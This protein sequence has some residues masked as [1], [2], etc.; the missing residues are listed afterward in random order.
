MKVFLRSALL[1][2]SLF[3]SD[4]VFA[5]LPVANFT[6]TPLTG[7]APLLVQFTSTSTGNP[8]SYQWNL[9]NGVNTVQQNPSTAY[10]LPGT[11]TVT[12]TVTNANGSDT[13]VVT[14]YITVV[15]NPTIT[16]AALDSDGCP[17]FP[18]QFNNTT[19]FNA[20]GAGTY[21]WSFG[22]G[23]I[24]SATNPAHTYASPGLYNVTLIAT[25]SA[26]CAATL[27]K[28]AYINV[29]TPP[30]ATFTATPTSYCGTPATIGFTASSTGTGPHTYSWDFGDGGTGVGASPSHVYT[31]SGI[32][33]VT[34][35]A[36]DANG[37]KD[38]VVKPNYVSVGSIVANFTTSPAA[39][40]VNAPLQFNNT[41]NGGVTYYWNFGDGN[42][43]TAASPAHTYMAPG[44]YN[45]KLAIYD[46]PCGDSVTKQITV[47][48]SPTPNF[49]FTPNQPCPAPVQVQFNNFTSGATSYAWDFGDGGTSS[50]TSP[51]HTYGMNNSFP[52]KLI[53]TN[54][55]GCSAEY[56]DT[57]DVFSLDVYITPAY[58]AGCV[59][60]NVNFGSVIYWVH[61][62]TLGW[63]TYPY[64]IT[65]YSW[66]FGDG[67]TSALQSPSHSY[68]NANNTY[69]AN[70]TVTTANGCTASGTRLVNVGSKPTASFID[71]PDTVCVKTPVYFINTTTDTTQFTSYVW[72]MG[73]GNT[74]TTKNAQHPYTV[75]GYYNVSLV[76]ENYG[77]KD[78]FT[79]DTAAVVNA[80]TAIWT[81]R[82]SCDTPLLVQFY[83]TLS[84]RPTSH[85]WYFGDGT[86]DT[87][88]NPL[89]AYPSLG[90][91]TVSLVTFN[92]LYGCS[93]TETRS[94]EIIDPLL[95]FTT[96]DTAICRGD[97]ILFI[98]NYTHTPSLYTW[99][100]DGL[101]PPWPFTP[102]SNPNPS[103]GSWGHRFNVKGIYDISVT[104]TDIHGCKDSAYRTDYVLVAKPQALFS[105]TPTVGCVPLTVLF[106]DTSTNVPGA[107]SVTRNWTFGNGA[108]TVNTDTTSRIYP[109]AGIY[110]V[111][112][113]VTDNV[114]CKDTLSKPNYIDVRKPTAGFTVDDSA[115]CI[116]QALNFTSNSVGIGLSAYWDFGDGTNSAATNPIKSYSQAGTFSVKLIVTDASG[117]KD[118]LTK[119]AYITITKPNAAFAMSDTQAI[120]PPLTVIFT[121]Q[122]QGATSYT[123][124]FGSAGGSSIPS[125]SVIFS[126]P[127]LYQVSL[128]VTDQEGCTDTAYDQV[129]V[130][131]YAG[132]LSYSPLY[133]CN[134]LDVNFTSNIFGVPSMI[135][136][137]NDGVT[138][139]VVN[140]TPITHKYISPGAYLPKL[141]LSDNAGC[142]NSSAGLDTIKVDEVT[143]GFIHTPA[144]VNTPVIFTD[145][146]FT[147]FQPIS[148]WNWTFNAQGTSTAGTPSYTFNAVG[149]YS[150]TLI[151]T[152]AWGCKDTITKTITVNELPVITAEFDTTICAGDPTQLSAFGGVTYA[153]APAGSLSCSNCQNPVAT[154]NITT[155]YIVTGTDANG[156]ANKDSVKITVRYYTTSEVA[157]GG[158]ICADSIFQLL[159]FG[160]E[161]YEW[162]PAESLDNSKIPNPMASPAA[163][164][165]Y[166]VR[167]WEASCLADSHFV[168]VIVHPKPNVDAGPDDTAFAGKEIVLIASSTDFVTFRWASSPTLSCTDCTAPTATPRATT[169]YRVTAISEKGCKNS[170]S[171]TIFILCHND[172]VFVPNTF[173]PNG[174]GQ[175]DVF[176][177]RGVG[178]KSIRSFRIY[179]RWGEVVFERGNFLLNDRSSGWDGTYKGQ[180]L[181]TDIFIYAI[182]GICDS[183]E[184]LSWK[185]D[186]TLIR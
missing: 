98:P 42:T 119:L 124:S 164:T 127:G 31:V 175:N 70:L 27:V 167:A 74:V 121:N 81:E 185:G 158:E 53:A 160:A 134:P 16:F 82:Y 1:F 162:T 88:T 101:N 63:Y 132:G 77:C 23:N 30:V 89:H 52:V 128:V 178:M 20:P 76:A 46:G 181:N 47:N 35:I 85:I 165:T 129:N 79:V 26:G 166:M 136:D 171:V 51:S 149:T 14:N 57:V 92:S 4:I 155:R 170:D 61:P 102:T 86:S 154:P 87:S 169:N 32:Y 135:W 125:P 40:C 37:C 60:L 123:W 159:A 115:A 7:C 50:Q 95:S 133:G 184:T 29:F 117:C 91:Y 72:Y 177:P 148:A 39:G 69:G 49:T 168:K 73:D 130:L 48:P 56:I 137:F 157:P 24:S 84:I 105:A 112:L 140:N 116:G 103:S 106:K 114:G 100:I 71:F 94:I 104:T 15:P 13:K 139:P 152:T 64:P 156:C 183:G 180:E 186:V 107:Y 59:P 99:K 43:S 3:Y 93:D 38:T 34:V 28:P 58:P 41:S 5:Q 90:T 65:S 83:D 2:L 9:G 54:V 182:D 97:S 22:D 36:T 109:T 68:V 96:A 17:P 33:T 173:T 67:G 146:S 6:A 78:T 111:Q 19:N 66:N 172:Q 143:A 108:A 80:P 18:V 141:I 62:I 163:T 118:S 120:C 113:I 161:R 10:T 122:S 110:S 25:N 142:T 45:V 145:T 131:G 21:S 176:Y 75:S 138:Q 179:N 150:V 55:F 8:T 151:A 144:C 11:Y 12:L 44:V 126:S 147:Y 153:W 174:D